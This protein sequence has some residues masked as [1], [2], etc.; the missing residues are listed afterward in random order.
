MRAIS[1]NQGRPRLNKVKITI[2]V[3]PSARQRIFE[4]AAERG[5]SI[6]LLLEEMFWQEEARIRSTAR[7]ANVRR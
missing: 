2:T 7:T 4:L 5:M 1:R 6:G 3:T